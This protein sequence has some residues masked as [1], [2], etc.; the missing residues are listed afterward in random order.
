[1][2]SELSFGRYSLYHDSSVDCSILATVL[3]F[4]IVTFLMILKCCCFFLVPGCISYVNRKALN[5]WHIPR[6]SFPTQI[7]FKRVGWHWLLSINLTNI[8]ELGQTVGI[9]IVRVWIIFNFWALEWG[10]V[11]VWWSSSDEL[12]CHIL[13]FYCSSTVFACA[14]DMLQKCEFWSAPPP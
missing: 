3:I 13:W 7:P 14:W 2:S 10:G 1:M 6:Q 4:I 11:D 5:R 12:A 8:V 9:W